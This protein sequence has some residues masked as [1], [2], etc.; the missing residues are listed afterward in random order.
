MAPAAAVVAE[1]APLTMIDTHTHTHAHTHTHRVGPERSIHNGDDYTYRNPGRQS[2][3]RALY[4]SSLGFC[5]A[6]FLFRCLPAFVYCGGVK[7]RQ[8]NGKYERMFLSCN[9]IIPCRQIFI[10]FAW[11]ATTSTRWKLFTMRQVNFVRCFKCIAEK[12]WEL[13]LRCPSRSRVFLF[14]DAGPTQCIAIMCNASK[15]IVVSREFL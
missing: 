4:W 10:P 13:F 5:L 6:V 11:N 2:R 7:N 8:V 14:F 1:Y 12:S 3:W 15:S 9:I